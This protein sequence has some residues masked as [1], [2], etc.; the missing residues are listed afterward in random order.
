MLCDMKGCAGNSA[1]VVFRNTLDY[2]VLQYL[3][4]KLVFDK[5]TY[6]YSFTIEYDIARD[7][8]GKGRRVSLGSPSWP[9]I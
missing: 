7:F 2:I 4:L 1:Y 6:F 9:Q 3:I 8:W 5:S